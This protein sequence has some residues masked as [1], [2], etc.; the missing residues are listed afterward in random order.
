MRERR[1]V[2]LR[3]TVPVY[4]TVDTRIRKRFCRVRSSPNNGWALVYSLSD[5]YTLLFRYLTAGIFLTFITE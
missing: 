4:N 2:G 1:E 3:A 5:M